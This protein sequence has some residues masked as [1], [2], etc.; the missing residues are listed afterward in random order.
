MPNYTSVNKS[1]INRPIFELNIP[2]ESVTPVPPPPKL[3]RLAKPT[4][5]SVGCSFIRPNGRLVG[6]SKLRRMNL[7]FDFSG[8]GT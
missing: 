7:S 6:L 5:L 8:Q 1:N 3:I 2:G 4:A